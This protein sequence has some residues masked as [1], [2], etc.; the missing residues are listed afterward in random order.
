MCLPFESRDLANSR[1]F[2]ITAQN[3]RTHF[4]PVSNGEFDN[5]DINQF[6][7]FRFLVPGLSTAKGLGLA[8][9]ADDPDVTDFSLAILHLHE[10]SFLENLKR[11]WWE[12]SNGC[13]QEQET[14]KTLLYIIHCTVYC[15]SGSIRFLTLFLIR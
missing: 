3:A 7:T 12:S 11:K 5:Y 4:Q 9:Q 10:N 14:S 1:E 15:I 13:P 2:Y 8:F 6:S